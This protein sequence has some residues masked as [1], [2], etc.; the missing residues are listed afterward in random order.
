MKLYRNAIILLG[1]LLVLVGVYFGVTRFA[2][3][4]EAPERATFDKI[5]NLSTSNM[6]EMTIENKGERF[7]FEKINNDWS[8]KYPE[9]IKYDPSRLSSSAINFSSIFVEKVIEE[10]AT[11]FAQYGLKDPILITCELTDGEKVTLEVGNMTPAKTAF[12]VRK[13]GENTV[14]TTDTYTINKVLFSLNELRDKTLVSIGNPFEEIFRI[15]LVRGG[16]TIFKA[17][18]EEGLSHTWVLTEPIKGNMNLY[19]LEPLFMA[20]QNI[21]VSEFVESEPSDLNKYG[22]AN[23]AYVFEFETADQNYKLIMGNEDRVNSQI[24]VMLE[25][26]DEVYKISTE[27]FTFLDKPIEEIV[28]VFAYI[29]N[30]WDVERMEVEMDGYKLDLKFDMDPDMDNEKDKFYLNGKDASIILENRK[31]PFRL[32]YQSLIGITL[33][34]VEPDAVPQGEAEITFVYYL[35]KD[36]GVM[37]V[38]FIPKDERYY[39]VMRNGEYSGI[40]VDKRKFDQPESV[41]ESYKNLMDVLEAQ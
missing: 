11:D 8:L 9:N 3:Q 17:H 20:V 41:R 26:Y 28:E 4:E 5:I 40:L 7:V 6:K 37:K 34:V 19:A 2:K 21:T 27:L 30:I 36:P 38:E 29:V 25:G 24:F 18:N 10:E 22:L 39:Y 12:Y 15:S 33:S 16:A 1:V 32:Y 31:Q 35:K 14:Y 23:P 13:Q